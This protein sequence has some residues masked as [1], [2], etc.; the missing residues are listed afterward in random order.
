MLDFFAAVL[1]ITGGIACLIFWIVAFAAIVIE[2][3]DNIRERKSREVV[4]EG[5]AENS[6]P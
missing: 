2:V 1:L 5:G 4:E 6:N 3:N